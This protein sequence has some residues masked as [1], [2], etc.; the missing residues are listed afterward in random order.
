MIERGYRDGDMLQDLAADRLMAAIAA[1]KANGYTERMI[2]NSVE[3][4]W[5]SVPAAELLPEFDVSNC[6]VCGDFRGHGH[7]CDEREATP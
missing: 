4:F 3:V 5:A 7:E 2:L 6:L 1:Y